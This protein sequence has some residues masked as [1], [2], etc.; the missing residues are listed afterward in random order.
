MCV[1]DV[2]ACVRAVRGLKQAHDESMRNYGRSLLHR[3]GK[4]CV[5]NFC[6]GSFCRSL[7]RSPAGS[8]A[9]CCPAISLFYTKGKGA[10]LSCCCAPAAAFMRALGSFRPFPG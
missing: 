7:L 1:R 8:A 6:V 10:N 9:C 5:G 2:R 4:P 3:L